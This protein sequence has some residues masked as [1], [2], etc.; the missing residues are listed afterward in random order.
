MKGAARLGAKSRSHPGGPSLSYM[1]QF[2]HAADLDMIATLSYRKR[3]FLLSSRKSRASFLPV[4][5]ANRS[6]WQSRD[7]RGLQNMANPAN[8]ADYSKWSSEQL[9][10]RVTFLEEQLKEQTIRSEPL[11][12]YFILLK[13][14]LT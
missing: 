10:D 12:F 4:Y 2:H 1:I 14:S 3:Q 13:L 11:I 5:C 9:I 7:T 8:P 6:I